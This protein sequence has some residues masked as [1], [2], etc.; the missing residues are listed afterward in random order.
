LFGDANSLPKDAI[1]FDETHDV[2]A[3]QSTIW[4]RIIHFWFENGKNKGD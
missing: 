1:A 2:Q 3:V 4:R